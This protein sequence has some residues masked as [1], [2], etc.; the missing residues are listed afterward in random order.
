MRKATQTLSEIIDKIKSM[1]GKD[2]DMEVNRGRKRIEKYVAVIDKIYPSV[3]TVSIKEPAGSTNQSY[4]YSDV[5]CGDVKIR[6]K[7]IEI[8]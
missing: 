1:Q 2:V 7:Q 5:L 3:F 6:Q 8:S 4:S